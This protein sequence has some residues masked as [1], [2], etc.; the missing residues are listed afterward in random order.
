MSNVYY[1]LDNEEETGPYTLDE[2]SQLDIDIHTKILSPK[3]GTWEAAGDLPD[4]YPL[5]EARGIYLPTG[6]NLASFGWRFLAFVMDVIIMR[7]LMDFVLAILAYRGIEFNLTFKTTQDFLKLT[8]QMLWL[9]LIFD[10]TFILYNALCESSPMKGSVGKRLCKLVVVDANGNGPTILK[11]L[12][13]S[14]G[15]ALSFSLCYIG[16]ISIFFT[17]HKQALHDQLA[18]TYV[19]KL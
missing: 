7:L 16:Y 9:Q 19:V 1:V 5:F 6:D 3:T 12:L 17:E 11:A 18:K 13:R 15:K 14:F 4:L 10:I 2:L 8:P